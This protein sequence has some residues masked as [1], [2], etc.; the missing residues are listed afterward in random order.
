MGEL[1]DKTIADTFNARIKTP[2]V[3][4]VIA[5][6]VGLTILFYFSQKPQIIMYSRYI[7]NLSEY[8][9]QEAY[10]MRTMDRVRTGWSGDSSFVQAQTMTMREIVVSFSKEMDEIRTMGGKAPS[11]ESVGNF[12]REVLGKVAGMRRYASSRIQWYAAY[13]EIRSQMAELPAASERVLQ[14]LLDTARVGGVVFLSQ[15]NPEIEQ[16]LPDT[17]KDE[18]TA[19]FRANEEHALAWSRLNNDMAVMYSAD[20]MQFFQMQSLN[21]ISLKSKIPMAFYFLC[22]VLLLSTFFFIF[23]S[24]Q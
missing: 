1:K 10:A 7:K 16:G 22:L 11:Y 12:E 19:L 20:L 14:Q 8:Q 13:N 4:L 6:T 9:L 23:R 17:L 15:L 24:R 21:E 3:W 2:W 18:L 5:I